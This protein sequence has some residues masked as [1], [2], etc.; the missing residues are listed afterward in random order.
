MP[1]PQQVPVVVDLDDF[2]S[3]GVS[4]FAGRERGIKVRRD[5]GLDEFD[6][7]GTQVVVRVPDD[8]ITIASSF[9][10]GMFGASI[11]QHG[12]ERFRELYSFEGIDL[13]PV[14]RDA[15]REALETD[16]PLS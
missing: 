7:Q 15:I 9:F 14:I 4:V 11:R 5:A 8:V 6:K 16:S 10:L 12:E 1:S 13:E 2:R 3:P